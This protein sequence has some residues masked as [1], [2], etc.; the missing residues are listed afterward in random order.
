MHH[1][2]VHVTLVF[3]TAMYNA[4]NNTL[5]VF[6]SLKINISPAF[7]LIAELQLTYHRDVQNVS[8][9]ELFTNPHK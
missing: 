3:V 5:Y 2:K 7:A 9:E 4:E 1:H 6:L 8:F